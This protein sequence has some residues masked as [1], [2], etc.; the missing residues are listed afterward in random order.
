M[1]RRPCCSTSNSFAPPLYTQVLLLSRSFLGG[2]RTKEETRQSLISAS[3]DLLNQEHLWVPST[4][5]PE[6][7][8]RTPETTNTRDSYATVPELSEQ[9]ERFFNVLL[10]QKKPVELDINTMTGGPSDKQPAN[11]KDDVVMTDG[12]LNPPN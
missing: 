7:E 2:E 3:F 1:H 9:T 11:L 4:T 8:R 10:E 6:P 12:T 5:Q